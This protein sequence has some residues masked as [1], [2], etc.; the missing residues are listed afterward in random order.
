MLLHTTYGSFD[1]PLYHLLF[2]TT[3]FVSN[4]CPGV[5]HYF[6]R[7]PSY[8]VIIQISSDRKR[9]KIF[10]INS[11]RLIPFSKQSLKLGEPFCFFEALK[12]A[13]TFHNC[14]DKEGD[15]Q[16]MAYTLKNRLFLTLNES[17]NV[18]FAAS[19]CSIVVFFS[20]GS[21][22]CTNNLLEVREFRKIVSVDFL[23]NPLIGNML[24]FYAR[25]YYQADLIKYIT[26]QIELVQ[27]NIA[28]FG[29]EIVPQ[30]KTSAIAQSEHAP[31]AYGVNLTYKHSDT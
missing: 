26:H 24:D 2:K 5:K 18:C 15:I 19:F 13:G 1:S 6:E 21:L 27:A 14:Q 4:S 12:T 22:F 17:Q 8:F 10:G 29:N 7:N 20:D 11:M 28:K 25:N 23:Q 16:I 31:Y 30:S 3:K 9:Y